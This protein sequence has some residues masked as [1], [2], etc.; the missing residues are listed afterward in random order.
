[1]R[2]HVAIFS[3]LISLLLASVWQTARAE[4]IDLFLGTALPSTANPN[5][6]IIIDNSASGSAY[7]ENTCGGDNKK[8]IMEKCIIANLVNS[9]DVTDKVNMGLSVFSPSGNTS[10]AYI[11]YH[12]RQMTAGNKTA[13]AASVGGVD[14][15]NNADRKSVV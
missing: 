11:R 14:P 12:V 13:L 8:M 6:L 10:G 3:T 2:R 7:I 15:A 4:D 5:V 9:A 1:M